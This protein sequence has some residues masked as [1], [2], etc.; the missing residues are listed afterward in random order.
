MFVIGFQRSEMA[1]FV[2]T[3]QM[4]FKKN[5]FAKRGLEELDRSVFLTSSEGI[6]KISSSGPIFFN[7]DGFEHHVALL[8]QCIDEIG[9]T[10]FHLPRR[11]QELL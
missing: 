11:P 6:H 4:L 8:F 7:H 5:S 1:F 10:S 2:H 3:L 9:K